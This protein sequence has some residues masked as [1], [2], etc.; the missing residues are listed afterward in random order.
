M[1]FNNK[2]TKE[3]RNEGSRI[4]ARRIHCVGQNEGADPAENSKYGVEDRKGNCN[5]ATSEVIVNDD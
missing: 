3:Q 4:L 5:N 1:D 2:G